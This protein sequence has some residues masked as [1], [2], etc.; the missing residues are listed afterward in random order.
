VGKKRRKKK[1]SFTFGER[2]LYKG[3]MDFGTTYI[4]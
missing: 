1:V 3:G 4:R 2:V